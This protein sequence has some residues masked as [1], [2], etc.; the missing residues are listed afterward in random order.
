M[1]DPYYKGQVMGPEL[2]KKFFL[3]MGVIVGAVLATAVCAG[4]VCVVILHSS[5][6]VSKLVAN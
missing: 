1:A 3:T 4:I 5:T 6:I 2:V